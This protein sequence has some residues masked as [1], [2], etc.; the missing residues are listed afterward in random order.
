MV[1]GLC[2]AQIQVASMLGMHDI[3]QAMHAPDLR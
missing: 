3:T 1:C 2:D